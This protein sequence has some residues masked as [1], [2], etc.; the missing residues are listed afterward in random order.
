MA[1]AAWAPGRE[2]L[3]RRA[4]DSNTAGFRRAVPGGVDRDKRTVSVD[5]NR[6]PCCENALILNDPLKIVSQTNL[7]DAPGRP[8]SSVNPGEGER[9]GHCRFSS[10]SLPRID[11]FY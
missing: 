10:A 4:F 1:S 6:A 9:G 3:L 7:L 2:A 11:P 5:E 8:T